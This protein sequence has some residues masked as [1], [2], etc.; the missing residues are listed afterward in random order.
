MRGINGKKKSI[1]EQVMSV[2]VFED[3][4]HSISVFLS[5]VFLPVLIPVL[6]LVLILVPLHASMFFPLGDDSPSSR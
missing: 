6:V 3:Y 5:F 4:S 2:L 1:R